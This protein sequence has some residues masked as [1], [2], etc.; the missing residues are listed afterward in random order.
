MSTGGSV[1][2]EGTPN[3]FKHVRDSVCGMIGTD[4]GNSDYDWDYDQRRGGKGEYAVIVEVTR[5]AGQ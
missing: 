3:T 1:S 2:D 4:D 5:I